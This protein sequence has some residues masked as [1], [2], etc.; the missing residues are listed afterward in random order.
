MRPVIES[1][2]ATKRRAHGLRARIIT[3]ERVHNT[4]APAYRPDASLEDIIVRAKQ[5]AD[6]FAHPAFRVQFNS[7]ASFRH[8]AQRYPLVLRG[9]DEDVSSLISFQRKLAA[10]MRRV[11]LQVEA[12]FTPHVTLMWADRCI[13][14]Y[15]IA[16]IAWTVQ[17]F[18]LT[19]IFQGISRHIHVARWP[20]D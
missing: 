9:S 20:L 15:P 12:G 4:L 11:G 1:L 18:V 10:R 8:G 13:E 6:G 7:T 19:I 3:G 17:E 16:P 2:G 14:E 5:A